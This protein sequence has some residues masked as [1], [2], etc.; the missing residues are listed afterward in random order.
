MSNIT[1]TA[2]QERLLRRL[3]H[4]FVRSQHPD[5]IAAFKQ[6]AR[7]ELATVHLGVSQPD[8]NQWDWE[9]TDLGYRWLAERDKERVS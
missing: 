1:L 5:D 4:D 8:P 9:I 2:A 6:L 7:N 3:A